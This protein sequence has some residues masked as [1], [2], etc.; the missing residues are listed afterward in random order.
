[1][2][3]S[4]WHRGWKFMLDMGKNAS[5]LHNQVVFFNTDILETPQKIFSKQPH[6]Q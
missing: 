1:M 2:L 6:P 5:I 4:L 3:K